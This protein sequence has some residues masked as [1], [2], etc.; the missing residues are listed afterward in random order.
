MANSGLNP[1]ASNGKEE[2]A[3]GLLYYSNTIACR[4][5]FDNGTQRQV[6]RMIL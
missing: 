2:Q 5:F 6:S 3:R 1:A 4:R